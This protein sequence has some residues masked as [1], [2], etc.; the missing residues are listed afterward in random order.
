[1]HLFSYAITP[2]ANKKGNCAL[3]R[4][5]VMQTA[6]LVERVLLI[7]A[8]DQAAVLCLVTGWQGKSEKVHGCPVHC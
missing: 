2:S 3:T 5:T 6:R 1:M 4:L 7:G 8:E